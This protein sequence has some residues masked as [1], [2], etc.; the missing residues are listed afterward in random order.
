MIEKSTERTLTPKQ[1]AFAEAIANPADTR[2]IA[3]KSRAAG[4]TELYGYR[5]AR[6][7]HVAAE[8]ERATREHV[9]LIRARASRVIAAMAERAEAGDVGAARL[10]LEAAG[11]L[12]GKGV[13]VTVTTHNAPEGT[14]AERLARIREERCA[15][16]GA[17]VTERGLQAE[18]ESE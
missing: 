6:L 16:V 12:Q 2:S 1:L 15:K 18:L 11:I 5:L 9:Q 10:F 8:I 4:Y 13:A 3:E 17:L 7:P 14:F